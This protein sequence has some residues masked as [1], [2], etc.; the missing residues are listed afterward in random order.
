MVFAV[1]FFRHLAAATGGVGTP[2]FS[3][4]LA[5]REVDMH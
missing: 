5:T 2:A 3:N 1:T 4:V